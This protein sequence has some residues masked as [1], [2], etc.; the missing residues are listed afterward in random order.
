M[1]DELREYFSSY[2]TAAERQIT[3]DRDTGRSRGSGFV[4]CESEDTVL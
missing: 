2:G 1:S 4:T 3:I